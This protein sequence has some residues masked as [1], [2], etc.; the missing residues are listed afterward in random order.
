MSDL[1]LEQIFN[2]YET[3]KSSKHNYHEIYEPDFKKI[4]YDKINILEVG[5]LHGKSMEAW[6][7]YFPNAQVYGIDIF[8]RVPAAEVPVLKRKRTHWCKVDS[9]MS[10]GR[11]T[12]ERTW[13][14]IEFDFIL[15]D[16]LHT[17]KG[18]AQTYMTLN[19]LLKKGGTYYIEDV[20]VVD[21]LQEDCINPHHY[22]FSARQSNWFARHAEHFNPMQMN[23]LLNTLADAPYK[24]THHDNRLATLECD[25]YVIKIKK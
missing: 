22:A 9:T 18:Q 21:K 7:E 8:K 1:T 15:D 23:F 16:G 14:G 12:I 5:V 13:P 11:S 25:S 24:V 19:P 4:K 3:D 2:K 10:I 17:L 20:C 6:L